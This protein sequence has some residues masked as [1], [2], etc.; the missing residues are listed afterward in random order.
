MK[1][2]D[3]QVVDDGYVVCTTRYPEEIISTDLHKFYTKNA[4]CAFIMAKLDTPC[5]PKSQDYIPIDQL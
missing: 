2:I 3:I 5:N 4:V 1:Y